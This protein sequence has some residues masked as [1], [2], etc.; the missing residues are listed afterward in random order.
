MNRLLLLTLAVPA[1]ALAGC[2]TTGEAVAEGEGLCKAEPGQSFVGQR[3]TGE[4]GAQ[5]LRLT[6]AKQLRWGPPR[7]AMTMDFRADRLTV[8]YDDAMTIT[9]VSCG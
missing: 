5:L 3:A 8:S 2:A 1:F 9:R 7:T 4:V 6:G